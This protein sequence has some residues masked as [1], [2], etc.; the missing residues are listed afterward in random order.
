[1]SHNQAPHARL[2]TVAEFPPGSF[3]ENL[4]VRKDG[5]VLI[6]EVNHRGLL[7]RA[8]LGGAG[9]G[10]AGVL[11]HTFDQPTVGIVEVEPDV[12]LVCATNLYTTHESYLH[13]FDLRT[14]SPGEPLEPELAF[15]FPSEARGP[16]GISLFAPGGDP[17]G[18]LFRQSDLAQ[19]TSRASRKPGSG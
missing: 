3:L 18:R 2:T 5:S 6:T 4:V 12:V 9:S 14:W 13:R 7:V 1:M 16:N 15:T 17:G 19:S 8:P 11:L 10:H